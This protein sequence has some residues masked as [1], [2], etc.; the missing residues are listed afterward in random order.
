METNIKQKILASISHI[1]DEADHS[2]LNPEFFE[3]IDTELCTLSDYFHTSKNQ[4]LLIAVI[5]ALTCKGDSVDMNDLSD[6]FGCNPIKI[7]EFSDD[8]EYLLQK[9]ILTKQRSNKR[10]A[11]GLE[12][13]YTINE[14]IPAAILQNE[15]MPD[16]SPQKVENV[17]SLLEK[18]DKLCDQRVQ[19]IISTNSLFRETEALLTENEHFPLI[20]KIKAQRF[21]ES[22]TALFLHLIWEAINS[23]ESVQ[24]GGTIDTIFDSINDR[25]V[26]MQ[27]FFHE[28]NLLITNDWLEVEKDHYLSYTSL[29]LSERSRTLLGECG[30]NLFTNEKKKDNILKPEDIPQ[31]ELVFSESEMKQLFLLKDLLKPDKLDAMQCWLSLKNMPKGITVLLHGAP[32]TGKTEIV[33]QLARET[34]RRLMKI[35]ISQSKSMWFG[36]SEKIVKRMF[37]D[38]KAYAKKCKTTPILFFNEADAILSKRKG[39]G[40][41]DVAQTEN[42]I[43]NILLEE[44]ENF[45][46]I[47]FATT[48]LISNLD[49]AFDR[50]FLF[51]NPFSKTRPPHQ[52]P[53]LE[54]Q[55][56]G[57]IKYRM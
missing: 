51:Q 38:Y 34:D 30:I 42:A 3:K 27:E 21:N 39:V 56:S 47:L 8:F 13:Q 19:E 44:I 28:T 24:L 32:G 53:N 48:N 16:L 36:E 2:E 35:E 45:E 54:T 18:I 40:T 29:S 20:A 25:L 37:T 6:L 49:N 46:G 55:N 52:N 10:K 4:S 57:F 15:P 9:A 12:K 1:Y 7:L 26:Y 33:R 22:D 31:R 5:L 43:Q 11:H 17:F 14:K 23:R 50:R 41:S